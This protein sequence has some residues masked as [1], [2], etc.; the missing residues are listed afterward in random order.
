MMVVVPALS[1]S[2]KRDP[3]IVGG[4]I[5]CHESAR[6]PGVGNGINHPGAVQADHCA[7]E[8]APQQ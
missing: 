5:A 2:Q 6:T 3:P 8:D 4:E 7:Q 1:E